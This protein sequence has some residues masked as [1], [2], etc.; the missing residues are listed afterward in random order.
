MIDWVA[1]GE[2]V[3]IRALRSNLTRLSHPKCGP[4][5]VLL[6]VTNLQYRL[7]SESDYLLGLASFYGGLGYETSPL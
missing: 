3:R 7:D 1:G 6:Q 4:G 2:I 5:P